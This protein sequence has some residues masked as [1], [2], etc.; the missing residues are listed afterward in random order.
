MFID[1]AAVTAIIKK[2]QIV[3]IVLTKGLNT[4]FIIGAQYLSAF[5]TFLYIYRP[6]R[7]Y[8]TIDIVSRLLS[9]VDSIT[10]KNLNNSGLNNIP[11]LYIRDL[12]KK[13]SYNILL[14][15]RTYVFSTILL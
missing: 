12:E 3:T 13:D 11:V 9:K 5:T 14:S 1:Y 4:R 10:T 15:N 2:S 7:I 6:S 8:L